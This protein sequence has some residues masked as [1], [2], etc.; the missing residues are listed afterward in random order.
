MFMSAAKLS[1]GMLR[2]WIFAP[3]YFKCT[4][5]ASSFG[6]LILAVGSSRGL[7]SACATAWRCSGVWFGV[8]IRPGSEPRKP[9]RSARST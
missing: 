9:P 8:F 4:S 1:N 6:K 5:A 3:R 2:P 7:A